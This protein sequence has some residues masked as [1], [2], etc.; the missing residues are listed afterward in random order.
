MDIDK[1]NGQ[2]FVYVPDGDSAEFS[3]ELFPDDVD[4]IFQMVIGEADCLVE[5]GPGAGKSHL[6][7]DMRA[8]CHDLGMASLTL[9]A[10]INGGSKQGVA[11]ALHV[12]DSFANMDAEDSVLLIDNVDYY[13]YSKRDIKRRYRLAKEHTQVALYLMEW[14][15]DSQAPPV[16]A[17]SHNGDWRETHWLYG[18]KYE[19][20][21]VTD[22]AEQL[23]DSFG[24]RYYF[25]GELSDEVA[26]GLLMRRDTS[27]TPETTQ[28]ML[29]AVKEATG[30]ITYRH[31][32]LLG[33]SVLEAGGDELLAEI[34]KVDQHTRQLTG[35]ER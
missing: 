31:I 30:K 8:R 26:T 24:A 23:L 13:G 35:V 12:L 21:E 32:G 16:M 27:I 2:G 10:H 4:E 33:L 20:D 15:S 14:L 28:S 7:N 5:A 18:K 1:R 19:V 25:S 3:E 29:E 11:N 6:V 9:Y 34:L 17:T 22:K